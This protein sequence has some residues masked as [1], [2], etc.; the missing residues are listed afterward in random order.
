MGLNLLSGLANALQGKQQPNSLSTAQPSIVGKVLSGMMGVP[1]TNSTGA[2]VG[3]KD[4]VRLISGRDFG[5]ASPSVNSGEK[6]GLEYLKAEDDAKKYLPYLNSERQRRGLSR[7][8]AQDFVNYVL[9]GGD[10]NKLRSQ[11]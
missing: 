4:L 6:G 3:V 9:S 10:W 1:D 5:G 11:E 2:G 8:T 7:L